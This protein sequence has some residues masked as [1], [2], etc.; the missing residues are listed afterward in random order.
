MYQNINEQ[1]SAGARQFAETAAQVNR[2][3]LPRREGLWPELD[4][5]ENQCRVAFWGELAEVRD[6]RA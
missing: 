5:E 4:L 1:F 2:R 3:S 6:S